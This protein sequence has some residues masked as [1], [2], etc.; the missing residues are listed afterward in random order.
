MAGPSVTNDN[1]NGAQP[2][3]AQAAPHIIITVDDLP[4]FHMRIEGAFPNLD[5]ALN[6][7]AQATRTL[8][9]QYRI[10]AAQELRAQQ[11]AAAQNE[12]I[13]QALQKAR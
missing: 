5:Y 11:I 6:M 7:L 2:T 12:Q 10:A 4:S 1:G 9:T 13:R 3:A 8:E